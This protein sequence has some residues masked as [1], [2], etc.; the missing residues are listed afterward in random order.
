MSKLPTHEHHS[1]KSRV[2][3]YVWISS[4][5]AR[6]P[7]ISRGAALHSSKEA[8]V[9]P[10]RRPVSSLVAERDPLG[11]EIM[12]PASHFGANPLGQVVELAGLHEEVQRFA[13]PHSEHQRHRAR[14]APA[15][16]TDYQ[17]GLTA[18]R[19]T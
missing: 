18:G 2:P 14:S 10:G 19:R 6:P 13:D 1:Q 16:R 11:A 5:T 4:A 12:E 7:P 8:G 9:P 15:A 3:N 17:T